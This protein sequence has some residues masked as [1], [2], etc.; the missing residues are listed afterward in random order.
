[1]LYLA[2]LALLFYLNYHYMSSLV[3]YALCAYIIF[4][5]AS[6]IFTRIIYKNIS[7]KLILDKN[8]CSE[9]DNISC[10]IN[11]FLNLKNRSLS[12]AGYN[13]TFPYAISGELVVKDIN[14]KVID[15][16]H[17]NNEN[18]FSVNDKFDSPGKYKFSI[19]KAKITGLFGLY[20]KDISIS[21]ESD[22]IVYPKEE[23]FDYEQLEHFIIKGEG[24]Y[25]NRRGD[26]Y[27]EI[28]EVK[29]YEDG[30]DIRHI[31]AGLT[32]GSRIMIKVGT[33]RINDIYIYPIKYSSFNV[34]KNDLRKITYFICNKEDYAQLYVE[35]KGNTYSLVDEY[36]YKDFVLKVYE[37][38][39]IC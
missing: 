17:F 9:I 18:D 24:E 4:G 23:Q 39:D 3:N 11:C 35:Y 12:L 30:D 20:K 27:S 31:H 32:D 29:E 5:L 34:V 13:S 19:N 10:R 28:Y 2:I 6:L 14:G 21:C 36:T 16:M 33:D 38:F 1:M 7:A 8:E 37:D 22:L 15:K 25:I 26:D